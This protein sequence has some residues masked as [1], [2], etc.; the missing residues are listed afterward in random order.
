M[1]P[2]KAIA[3]YAVTTLSLLTRGLTKSIGKAP[4]VH[5]VPAI[6]LKASKAF[7]GEKVRIAVYPSV[8]APPN[9]ANVVK[10]S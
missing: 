3:T 1:A 4:W 2:T 8:P 10:N 5:V 6:T 7:Q 9:P